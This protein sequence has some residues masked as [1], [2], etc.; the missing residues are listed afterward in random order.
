MKISIITATY[1]SGTTLRDTI[2]SVL[3]QTYKD[4]EYIIVDGVSKDNT[5][6][7]AREYESRF[8]GRM[9]IISEPDKGIYDA[10]NKGIAAATGDVV[11]ILNSDDLYNGDNVLEQIVNSYSQNANI[12]GI[13]ADLYY[14]A[15]NDISKVV[16][17]WK[18]C[19]QKSFAKGWHP[20]HPTFYLNRSLYEQFDTFDL[21]YSLA[22]DFELMLRYLEKYHINVKYIEAPLVRM[23]LG[24][25]TSKNI[26]NIKKGNIECIRA[27]KKNGI[28]APWYYPIY[29]LVPKLKQFFHKQH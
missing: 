18:S 5:L 21:S 16:R 23:R 8:E 9:R 20:A 25:A 14:V 29:R 24:G 19:K 3:N 13:Y 12:D 6:E 27:F 10:M 1:N 4:I 15:Q 7:I 17:H 11:G 22:A 28:Y 2:E 26:S